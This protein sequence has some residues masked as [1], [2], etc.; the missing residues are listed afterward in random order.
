[1]RPDL[2]AVVKVQE[3]TL[4]HSITFK[5]STHM[6]AASTVLV[7]SNQMKPKVWRGE[8][9]YMYLQAQTG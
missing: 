1:M 9:H 5:T 7:K 2:L 4:H 8:M 3:G 6:M